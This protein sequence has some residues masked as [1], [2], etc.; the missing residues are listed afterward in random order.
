MRIFI[1]LPRNELLLGIQ[2]YQADFGVAER[3]PPS[4]LR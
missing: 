4:A 1:A 2:E 3:F